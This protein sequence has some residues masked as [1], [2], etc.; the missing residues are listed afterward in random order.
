MFPSDNKS[1][2]DSALNTIS[3]L[4]CP[5]ESITDL[6]FLAST[7]DKAGVFLGVP[8]SFSLLSSPQHYSSKKKS[9]S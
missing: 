2:L 3:F 9:S 5:N 1:D 7:K 4:Y 8:F 6:C